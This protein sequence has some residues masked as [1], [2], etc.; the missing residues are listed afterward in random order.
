[1]IKYCLFSIALITL[2]S[3]SHKTAEKATT[4]IQKPLPTTPSNPNPT[5]K[6][7]GGDGYASDVEPD[8]L[9]SFK[10]SPCFGKCP[11]FETKLYKDGRA[12]YQGIAYTPRKGM[13][14]TKVGEDVFQA[15]QNKATQIKFANLS[16][17]FP[18]DGNFITDLPS[19]ITFLRLG[20]IEKKI[21]DNSYA[22]AELI[23]FENYLETTFENLAW[24][25]PK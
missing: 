9:V 1:M 24:K 16:S 10:R 23:N 25:E 5:K 17:K 19:T 15:I 20:P 18:T 22:P 4:T 8:L 13:F 3:C 14:E 12:T 21:I 2:F 6:G 7:T 11:S